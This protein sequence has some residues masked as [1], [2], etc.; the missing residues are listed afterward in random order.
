MKVNV[1]LL[2]I[3]ATHL[4]Q[5]QTPDRKLVEENYALFTD[6]VRY[7]NYESA[8]KRLEWLLKHA[9]V[10]LNESIYI[11]GIKVYG[12]LAEK[13]EQP[14]LRSFYKQRV[15]DLFDLR[16][17]GSDKKAELLDRKAN[18]AFRLYYKEPEH[19]Q[20]VFEILQQAFELNKENIGDY[21]LIPYMVAIKN[22]YA[23]DTETTFED[24]LV[25]YDK[26]SELI[27]LKIAKTGNRP[28]YI[29]VQEK[30][31]KLI[32]INDGGF[33]C[34]VISTRWGGEFL[35]DKDDLKLA[36]KVLKYGLLAKC[37]DQ[38]YVLD[39]AKVVYSDSPTPELAELIGNK[40]WENGDLE[41]AVEYFLA[42]NEMWDKEEKHY[43]LNMKVAKIY[44]TQEKKVL[45]R[46]HAYKALDADPSNK[47][48]YHLIGT[49]YFNSYE[50]CEKGSNAVKNRAVFLAAYEM[51]QKAGDTKS[52]ALAKANFPSVSEM[53]TYDL[54]EGDK[55]SVNCWINE[56]VTLRARD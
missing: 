36:K 37:T 45:S 7:G 44:S 20:L 40:S 1:L 4:L 11:N 25:I 21:N 49:L 9:P 31:D 47:A 33:T 35:K 51:Y 39:A 29:E 38:A 6:S 3:F 50:D 27:D 43:Q 17:A 13:E 28:K 42:A 48:P 15:L 24:V 23:S 55:I 19:H 30:I 26:L 10:H 5:G 53:H 16:I 41:S 12:G 32:P 18:V 46:S 54:R 34:D 22:L 52:M 2:L 14:E 8:Q 56:T